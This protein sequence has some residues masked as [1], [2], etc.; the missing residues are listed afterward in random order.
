[1]SKILCEQKNHHL[2]VISL[3][4]MNIREGIMVKGSER[5][6]KRHQKAIKKIDHLIKMGG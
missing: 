2:R 4:N 3:M 5:A 1:M 6:K